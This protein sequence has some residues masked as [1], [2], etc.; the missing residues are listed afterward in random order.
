MSAFARNHFSISLFIELFCLKK[1]GLTYCSL[2]VSSHKKLPELF[3]RK[4]TRQSSC[5]TSSVVSTLRY[6]RMSIANTTSITLIRVVI[7][8]RPLCNYWYWKKRLPFA[9]SP[10]VIFQFKDSRTHCLHPQWHLLNNKLYSSKENDGVRITTT[11]IFHV[12]IMPAA[13]FSQQCSEMFRTFF[14]LSYLGNT[15]FV[16]LR[17][18]K[19]SY[20]LIKLLKKSKRLPFHYIL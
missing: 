6:Q 1:G 3:N 2:F 17:Q 12:N 5:T 13:S 15:S 14:L 10:T 18:Y 20:S 8:S 7:S 19:F 11:V 16:V 9:Y 4:V